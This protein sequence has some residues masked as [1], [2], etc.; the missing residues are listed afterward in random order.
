[1]ADELESKPNGRRSILW[2]I[3]GDVKTIWSKLTRLASFITLP[4]LTIRRPQQDID[5]VRTVREIIVQTWPLEVRPPSVG[6]DDA[7]LDSNEGVKIFG[8]LVA[9]IIV[10]YLVAVLFGAT[11]LVDRRLARSIVDWL[12]FLHPAN[13]L[14]L[15]KDI[16]LYDFS[17]FGIWRTVSTLACGLFLAWS[18]ETVLLPRVQQLRDGDEVDLTRP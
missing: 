8:A 17:A 5:P 13:A 3:L 7:P 2:A 10:P 1:M 12:T 11:E 18:Y 14:F 6:V 15:A 9:L 16:V 4:A